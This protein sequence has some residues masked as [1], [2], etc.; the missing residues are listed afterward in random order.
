[1]TRRRSYEALDLSSLYVTAK[2]ETM[3]A[4]LLAMFDQYE[5]AERVRVDLVRD[6]TLGETSCPRRTT[7]KQ[8]SNAGAI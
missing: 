1:V 6:R 8:A 5:I 4:V 2:E 3:S 7:S